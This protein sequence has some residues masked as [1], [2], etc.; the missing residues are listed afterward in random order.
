MLC[1]DNRQPGPESPLM[2]IL[3]HQLGRGE[4]AHVSL[5][6]VPE[7]KAFKVAKLASSI[8]DTTSEMAT[9]SMLEL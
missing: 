1:V 6:Y 4:Q 8:R 3:S 5:R 9:H 7:N 2:S